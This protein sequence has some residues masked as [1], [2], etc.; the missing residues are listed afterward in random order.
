MANPVNIHAIVRPLE[1]CH[2]VNKSQPT[3]PSPMISWPGTVPG[4]RADCGTDGMFRAAQQIIAKTYTGTDMT[5]PAT[6]QKKLRSAIIPIAPPRAENTSPPRYSATT[7]APRGR[8]IPSWF[9]YQLAREG[10]NKIVD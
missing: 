3:S 2:I 7:P 8:T 1:L 4:G 5:A 6:P 10:L 9:V